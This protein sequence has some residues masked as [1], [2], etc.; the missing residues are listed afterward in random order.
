MEFHPV[1]WLERNPTAAWRIIILYMGLIFILSSMS[2]PPQPLGKGNPYAPIIEHATEYGIL[3]FLLLGALRGN[4]RFRGY[5]PILAIIIAIS[6]GITDEIHQSFVPYRNS[7]AF[8]VLV[9]GVGAV[10]GTVIGK[11]D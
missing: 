6:Y 9:D 7:D 5:A 2:M 11:K 4:E 1:R 8:D 3:G 10:V